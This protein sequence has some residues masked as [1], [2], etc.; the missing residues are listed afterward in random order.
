MPVCSQ[1]QD[2]IDS[3]SETKDQDL[4]GVSCLLSFVLFRD[5]LGYFLQAS[6][7]CSPVDDFRI[8]DALVMSL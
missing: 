4:G 5:W 6:G 2:S 7:N 1:S 8:S 3:F